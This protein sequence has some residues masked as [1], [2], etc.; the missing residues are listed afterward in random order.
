M[1]K[2]VDARL[3]RRAGL[4]IAVVFAACSLSAAGAEA[5]AGPQLVPQLVAGVH[6]DLSC[7]DPANHGLVGRLLAAARTTVGGRLRCF[8]QAVGHGNGLGPQLMPGPTEEISLDGRGCFGGCKPELRS[9]LVRHLQR[10]WF[11]LAL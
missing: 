5:A 6:V 2:L 8:A 11:E 4:A 10:L 7:A 9:G 3:L 1:E